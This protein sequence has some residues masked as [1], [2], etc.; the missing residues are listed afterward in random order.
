M[1]IGA[2]GFVDVPVTLVKT[3]DASG[4][5]GINMFVAVI[6]DGTGRAGRTSPTVTL[7]LV[8]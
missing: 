8:P 2:S 7:Q 3:V 1:T 6:K 5:T 4:T